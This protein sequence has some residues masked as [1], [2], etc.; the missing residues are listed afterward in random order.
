MREECACHID[1]STAL[2]FIS[3]SCR[4][5]CVWYHKKSRIPLWAPRGNTCSV[6]WQLR[7]YPR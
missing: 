4:A 1:R 7:R 5:P 6:V 3:S 2:G